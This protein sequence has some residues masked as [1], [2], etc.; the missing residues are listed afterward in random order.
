MANLES[1]RNDD[2][3]SSQLVSIGQNIV[4]GINNLANIVQATFPNWVDVPASA[5]ASGVAGQ[6]AYNGSFFYVCVSS[7]TWVR[8]ALSTF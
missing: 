2:Q 3:T 4:V 5:T 7:N 8:V 6:V 1:Q